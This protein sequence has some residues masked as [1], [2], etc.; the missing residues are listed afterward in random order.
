MGIEEVL[1][2]LRAILPLLSFLLLIQL[3]ILR[4]PLSR[5]TPDRLWNKRKSFQR[6]KQRSPFADRI[7][8][9][10]FVPYH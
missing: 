8:Q 6:L 1:M 4:D 7:S 5:V 9:T 2:T 3:L 10:N